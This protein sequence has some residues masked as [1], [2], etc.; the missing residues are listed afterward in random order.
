MKYAEYFPLDRYGH[1]PYPRA[2][3]HSYL[4]WLDHLN[5]DHGYRSTARHI[6]PEGSMQSEKIYHTVVCI[7][8]CFLYF[9]L[10]AQLQFYMNERDFK[11]FA[12][13]F[14]FLS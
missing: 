7:F 14:Y 4:S 1:T 2:S 10:F 5:Y 3:V 12:F 8:L 9:V 11:G 13:L 6:I